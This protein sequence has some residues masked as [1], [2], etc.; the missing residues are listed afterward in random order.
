MKIIVSCFIFWVLIFNCVNAKGLKNNQSL[1]EENFG[2]SDDADFMKKVFNGMDA[3][4]NKFITYDEYRNYLKQKF[5]TLDRNSNEILEKSEFTMQSAPND[6]SERHSDDLEMI[7]ETL[8]R[9]NDD[10]ITKNEFYSIQP[11][12][13]RR[14]DKNKDG[15]VSEEEFANFK[16]KTNK[17]VKK[18]K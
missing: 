5:E 12:H 3:D 11:R 7:F 9:N 14:M 2:K 16:L 17:K 8:D 18:K 1:P 4:G 15:L 6:T 13:F 10:R